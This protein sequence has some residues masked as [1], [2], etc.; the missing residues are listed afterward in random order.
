MLLSFFNSLASSLLSSLFALGVAA[1]SW[2][3][4]KIIPDDLLFP[5][6]FTGLLHY[7]VFC[8]TEVQS[9]TFGEHGHEQTRRDYIVEVI[10]KL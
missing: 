2:D 4:E 10:G 7:I 1:I 9:K 3:L 8:Q 6:F 5:T